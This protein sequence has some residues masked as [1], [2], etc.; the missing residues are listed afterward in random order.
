MRKLGITESEVMMSIDNE[1]AAPMYRT[2]S[3]KNDDGRVE[4]IKKSVNNPLALSSENSRELKA[5]MLKFDSVTSP[6]SRDLATGT[7]TRDEPL[8]VLVASVRLPSICQRLWSC[9]GLLLIACAI[10]VAQN[11]L[12]TNAAL[13][14]STDLMLIA[15]ICKPY[16]WGIG[17]G[18]MKVMNSFNPPYYIRLDHGGGR[19]KYI[20]KIGASLS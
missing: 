6:L 17:I 3:N 19:K 10:G 7:S 14:F 8:D 9:K 1:M 13:Y 11:V 20:L 4:H 5:D 16:E 12:C 15:G 18:F 2:S